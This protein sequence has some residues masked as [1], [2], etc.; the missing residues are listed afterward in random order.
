M[1]RRSSRSELTGCVKCGAAIVKGDPCA[2]CGEENQ[3]RPEVQVI[4][5]DIGNRSVHMALKSMRYR[6]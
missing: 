2:A 5:S 1:S 6:R 3:A 4:R